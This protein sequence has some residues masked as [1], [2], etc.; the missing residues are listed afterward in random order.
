MTV[1][2]TTG[3]IVVDDIETVETYDLAFVSGVVVIVVLAVTYR[4]AST[5]LFSVERGESV[6]F[7]DRQS[8]GRCHSGQDLTD[9]CGRGASR[10]DRGCDCG[11]L[12]WRRNCEPATRRGHGCTS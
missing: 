12:L 10:V 2:A 6:T 5:R 11:S 9:Q 1:T 3:A 4:C 8:L 7:Q